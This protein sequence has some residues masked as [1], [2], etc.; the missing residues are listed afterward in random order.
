MHK[1]RAEF[2]NAFF[3]CAA[4]ICAFFAAALVVL[5][6]QLRTA[7]GQADYAFSHLAVP[8]LEVAV[9]LA[10][11]GLLRPLLARSKRLDARPSWQYCVVLAAV[12]CIFWLPVLLSA[13][14]IADDWM[15]LAAASIRKIVYLHP[16]LSWYTLDSVD[17]NFRPLG[18]VLYVGYM[19]KIF[20]LSPVAFLTGNFIVNFAASLVAFLI[21]RELGYSHIAAIAAAVLYISRDIAFTLNAWVAALGD[22]LS[23]LLCGLTTLAILRA[24]RR[25]TSVAIS[26]HLLAWIFFV[27]ATLAKQSSFVAPLIVALVV[28]IRPGDVPFVPMVRRLLLAAALFLVYSATA[29]IVFFHAKKLFNATVPY[30]IHLTL[31]G[32]VSVFSYVTWYLIPDV[33]RRAPMLPAIAGLAIVV[34]GAVFVLRVPGALGRRPR[35]IG[36][37]VLAA[38]ASVSLFVVLPSRTAPYYGAMSAFWFSIAL[39]IVLTRFGAVQSDNLAA[40]RSCFIFCLLLALGFLSIQLKRIGLIPSGGYIEGSFETDQERVEYVEIAHLL[41]Q[42]P[43]KDTLVLT[44]CRKSPRYYASMALLADPRITRIL[45]YDSH[46]RMFLSNDLDGQR[47]KDDLSGLQDAQAFNWNIPVPASEAA[48]ETSDA[49]TLWLTFNRG[50]IVPQPSEPSNSLR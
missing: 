15:L 11:V 36:F 32:I 49:R 21:V 45:V 42:S 24:C 44:D 10:C 22:G 40:R 48:H 23:I 26:Y 12:F 27:F 13:G 35:D 31:S 20:G 50:N 41:A 8:L 14:F 28:L 1:N 4:A 46:R 18:T 33:Y 19:L 30:P 43:Q 9:F 38:A 6:P 7:N 16:G 5:K 47:P 29:A 34:A 37:A 3:A 17:G 2:E 39:G 25:K